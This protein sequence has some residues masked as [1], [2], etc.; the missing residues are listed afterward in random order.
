MKRLYPLLFL[1]SSGCENPKEDVSIIGVW[2][3]N[4]NS[5]TYNTDNV[6]VFLFNPDSS[7]ANNTSQSYG[8][9]R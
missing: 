6:N 7:M 2:V 9:P 3:S 1:I 5:N 4:S 8:G